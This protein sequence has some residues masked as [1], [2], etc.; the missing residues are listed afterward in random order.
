[1]SND[2]I[3][4]ALLEAS[5]GAEA[6]GRDHLLFHERCG[7][8]IKLSNSRRTAERRKPLDEFNNGVVMTHRSLRD[9]EMFEVITKQRTPLPKIKV[10]DLT[11][12]L[13]HIHV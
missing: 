3:N 7:S 1:M 2:F 9:D 5:Q 11:P 10:Q 12:S 13:L 8:L 6:A 4:G